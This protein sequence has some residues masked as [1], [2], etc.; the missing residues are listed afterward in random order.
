[1]VDYNIFKRMHPH[2]PQFSTETDDLGSEAM[3]KNEPPDDQFLALLPPEMHAFDLAAKTWGKASKRA[4]AH[5]I[6]QLCL[7]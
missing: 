7:N 1:M 6:Y 5:S 2:N 4:A 3:S